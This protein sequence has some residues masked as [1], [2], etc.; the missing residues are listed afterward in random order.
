MLRVASVGS[1]S[2]G[3]ATLVASEET[4]LLIDCGFPAREMLSRLDQLN[5]DIADI[6]AIL[7]THEHSDHIGGVAAVSKAAGAP[8]YA[9]HGTL[10]SGK[11]EGAQPSLRS[12]VTRNLLSVILK[13]RRSLCRTM[14][15][16]LFNTYSNTRRGGW[17]S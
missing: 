3:N 1:G 15:K 2:K 4:T 16:N 10:T 9:T 14:R 5:L 6:D 17:A 7:V 8:I 13:Y 12:R 11:L